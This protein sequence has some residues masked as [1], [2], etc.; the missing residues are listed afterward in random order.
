M[1]NLCGNEKRTFNRESVFATIPDQFNTL[2]ELQVALRQSGLESSNLIL[3]IDYTKSNQHTGYKTFF[4]QSLHS[5][6]A[7]D[8][9]GNFISNPYQQVIDIVGRTLEPF[10]DDKL[11][12]TFVFGDSATGDRAV[13]PFV[14]DRVPFGFN[15]VLQ[16][17][18]EITPRLTLSGPTNFAPIINEAI[19]ICKRTN[20]YHILIIIA[21]GEVIKVNETAN[22][23]VNATNYPLSIIMVGVGD[24]PFDLMEEFDD[25][26]PARKFDNFQF[27]NFHN[28]FTGRA[29]NPEVEFARLALQE[30]PDQFM[31]IRNLGLLE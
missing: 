19:K 3:G 20:Q 21:D 2:E 24:G 9:N 31:A 14:P 22:A 29:R 8:S 15:E 1:G 16:R 10:D 11:I 23:I 12:P 7:K 5:M 4:G 28:V 18:N 27:V 13:C 17:Y 25:K 6:Q 30:I 26:L